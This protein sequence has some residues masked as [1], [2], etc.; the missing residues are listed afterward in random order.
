MISNAIDYEEYKNN[1][2]PDGVF[3]QDKVLPQNFLQVFQF[4]YRVCFLSL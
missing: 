1:I 2:R 4:L 3:F